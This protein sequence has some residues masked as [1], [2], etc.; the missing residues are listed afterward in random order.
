M[1]FLGVESLLLPYRVLTPVV[2]LVRIAVVTLL[3]VT[4][5]QVWR[6]PEARARTTALGLVVSAL[7]LVVC[8]G[9]FTGDSAATTILASTACVAFA[10]AL[11]GGQL[12]TPVEEPPGPV[13]WGG[14]VILLST[15]LKC[16]DL[17]EW[18]AHLN[19]YSA[20]TGLRGIEAATGTWPTAIWRAQEYDLVNGGVSPLHL[21]ISWLSVKLFGGNVL[22]TRFAEVV[23]STFLLAVFWAWIRTRVGGTLAVLGLSAFAFSPWHLAQSRMGTFFSISVAVAIS[24]LAIA[25]RIAGDRRESA[26]WWAGFGTCCGLL[27]YAYTPIKVLYLF[28]LVVVT[29][30]GYQGWRRGLAAWWKG[31][32][33]AVAVATVMLGVQLGVPPRF[34]TM[35]RHDYGELATD[36]SVWHKNRTGEVTAHVQPLIVIVENFASNVQAWWWNAWYVD[37]VAIWYAPAALLAV[38]TAFWWLPSRAWILASFCLIGALPPLLVYPVARRSLVIWP[39]V[40]VFGALFATV[41]ARVCR[42]SVDRAWWRLLTQGVSACAVVLIG[43]HGLSVYASTNSVVRLGTYFGPHHR[44]DM[45]LEAEKL[46]PR[47]RAKFIGLSFEDRMVARVRL[48]DAATRT[49]DPERFTFLD[50]DAARLLS[51]LGRDGADCLFFLDGTDA[52]PTVMTDLAQTFAK[53]ALMQRY[54]T[55]GSGELLYKV[56]IVGGEAG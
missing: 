29:G 52:D 53:S 48:F 18:P 9:W 51:D 27:G 10:A 23:G 47:C 15:L 3:I 2:P 24:M 14:L 35:L 33:I 16:L 20:E 31:P 55:D 12:D 44:L 42:S 49:G 6:R 46:L 50:I 28:F 43:L 1:D 11:V 40:Y 22:A 30:L 13:W 56:L 26:L 19:A 4:L 54:S 21:P 36:T 41:V 5:V 7:A 38:I 32:A 17:G 39:L 8:R 45:L 25:E 34:G 37:D